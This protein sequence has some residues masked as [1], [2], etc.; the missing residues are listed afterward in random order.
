MPRSYQISFH[1]QAFVKADHVSPQ[2]IE[3]RMLA[4]LERV[5]LDDIITGDQK[6]E[7]FGYVENIKVTSER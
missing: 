3:E 7:C 4:A 5:V 2:R 1:V 6:G